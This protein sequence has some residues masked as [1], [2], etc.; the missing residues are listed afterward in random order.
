MY[1][2]VGLGLIRNA[3]AAASER[4]F[5]GYVESWIQFRCES[6]I[7]EFL[8]SAMVL[9]IKCV[10]FCRVY[11]VMG[12]WRKAYSRGRLESTSSL[13]VFL[14][15]DQEVRSGFYRSC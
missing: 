1:I 12:V 8:S 6:C 9:H 11:S 3:L 13:Y 10:G 7:P 4:T 14:Q 2:R 5:Q 15:D